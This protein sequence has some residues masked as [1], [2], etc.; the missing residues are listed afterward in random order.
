[1]CSAPELIEREILLHALTYNR[2]RALML[3]ATCVHFAPP[4][5]LRQRALTSLRQWAPI[6][7]TPIR[8]TTALIEADAP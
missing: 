1:M 8:P 4:T 7:A 3:E 5:R 6:L 2:A